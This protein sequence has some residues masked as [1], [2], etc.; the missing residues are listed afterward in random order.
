[1]IPVW[2][3]GVVIGVCALFTVILC[4][5][6]FKQG[7][8]RALGLNDYIKPVHDLRLRPSGPRK[9][10]YI[11][12]FNNGNVMF[13]APF[14]QYKVVKNHGL[15]GLWGGVEEPIDAD[16]LVEIDGI[17]FYGRTQVKQM[18]GQTNEV[19]RSQL[20]HAVAEKE[21]FQNLAE[22][23]RHDPQAGMEQATENLMG[24]ARAGALIAP[25]APNK[26]SG[27]KR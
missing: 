9:T 22:Q 24:V 4:I 17:Y 21:M 26:N 12:A 13:K 5:A 3:I 20:D 18:F 10:F 19:L 16:E 14:G 27:G 1:M 23:R 7:E 2:I 6:A 25:K 15:I 11:E 8:K